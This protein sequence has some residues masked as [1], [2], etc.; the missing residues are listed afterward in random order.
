MRKINVRNGMAFSF[1]EALGLQNSI[2]NNGLTNLFLHLVGGLSGEGKAVD[3]SF[4]IFAK[5]GEILL[6]FGLPSNQ[7]THI[8]EQSVQP[9]RS[10]NARAGVLE[11]LRGRPN[12]FTHQNKGTVVRV[13]FTERGNPRNYTFLTVGRNAIPIYPGVDQ[14]VLAPN[15][16]G[17]AKSY[18]IIL[19]GTYDGQATWEV[20]DIPLPSWNGILDD[21]YT[22]DVIE[23][24]S[25]E[26]IPTLY[27]G[28]KITEITP[29]PPVPENERFPFGFNTFTPAPIYPKTKPIGLTPSTQN[30]IKLDIVTN[31]VHSM[32][33][34]GNVVYEVL[35]DSRDVSISGYSPVVSPLTGRIDEITD[36]HKREDILDV[37]LRSIVD[38]SESFY[39]IDWVIPCIVKGQV[40]IDTSTVNT[41]WVQGKIGFRISRNNLGRNTPQLFYTLTPM[42]DGVGGAISREVEVASLRTAYTCYISGFQLRK[43]TIKS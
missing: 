19:L 29:S 17:T 13:I 35:R 38:T 36:T 1:A 20:P 28:Y 7:N 37:F 42:M 34:K 30:N 8:V 4:V 31:D 40:V 6:I 2:R 41:V 3:G 39:T 27:T 5:G 14:S 33:I 18:D 16:D 32:S 15:A 23:T 22:A 25:T 10:P 26:D 11:Q 24:L 12:I 9:P 21:K 43:N